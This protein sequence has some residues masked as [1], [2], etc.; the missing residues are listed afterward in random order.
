MIGGQGS[1]GPVVNGDFSDMDESGTDVIQ[2]GVGV[3][4]LTVNG[5]T[6]NADLASNAPRNL[7][8]DDT[9]S[10]LGKPCPDR[11]CQ[12]SYS[13]CDSSCNKMYTVTIPPLGAGTACPA[14]PATCAPGEGNCRKCW[15]F[16]VLVVVL[17]VLAGRSAG[18]SGG[19]WWWL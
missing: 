19:L 13:T 18:G 9:L 4:D 7:V 12:G 17:V 1:L 3:A 6:E 5:W 16:V 11:A 14:S 10:N 2:W 8:T 15:R